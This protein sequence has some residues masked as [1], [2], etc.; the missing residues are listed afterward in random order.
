M[1]L[2]RWLMSTLPSLC[3]WCV[4]SPGVPP[5]PEEGQCGGLRVRAFSSMQ[6]PTK[7]PAAPQASHLPPPSQKLG[8]ATRGFSPLVGRSAPG[9]LL[10]A[11]PPVGSG[12][13]RAQRS[14][15]LPAW[16][17]KPGPWEAAGFPV[18]SLGVRQAWSG[19]LA[20]ARLGSWE[21]M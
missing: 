20:A 7:S 8:E 11:M 4:S 16:S 3:W 17:M 10:A 21:P 19:D 12:E 9:V 1:K 14:A 13:L 18:R 2:L 15:G 6:L 5:P